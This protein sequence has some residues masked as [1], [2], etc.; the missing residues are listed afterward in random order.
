M[1]PGVVTK[2]ASLEKVKL[3]LFP[4]FPGPILIIKPIWLNL[5]FENTLF[6]YFVVNN[7]SLHL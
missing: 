7:L 5:S 3:F 6:K 1:N 4:I 2:K